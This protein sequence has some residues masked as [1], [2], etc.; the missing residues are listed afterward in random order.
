MPGQITFDNSLTINVS[1]TYSAGLYAFPISDNS[2]T[3]QLNG[4]TDINASDDNTNA[5]SILGGSV[6]I[7]NE[8]NVST[9]NGASAIE[10]AAINPTFGSLLT[11]YSPSDPQEPNPQKIMLEGKIHLFN[12][13]NQM[14]LDLAEGSIINSQLDI[15]QGNVSWQFH[16]PNAKWITIPGSTIGSQ[17][18]LIINF[19][20]G[21]TWQVP[22]SLDNQLTNSAAVAPLIIE[23]GGEFM[24][25]GQGTVLGNVQTELQ[26]GEQ[27]KFVLVKKNFADNGG[28]NL[29]LSTLSTQTDRPGYTLTLEQQNE[30]NEGYLYAILTNPEEPAPPDPSHKTL[31]WTPLGPSYS[32][33]IAPSSATI[34]QNSA[35][36]QQL[37]VNMVDQMLASKLL[38]STLSTSFCKRADSPVWIGQCLDPTDEPFSL[39]ALPLYDRITGR[40]FD[41]PDG[42]LGFKANIHGLGLQLVKE[43]SWGSIGTGLFNGKGDI[44]STELVTPVD[45]DADYLGGLIS[46][47]LRF[48]PFVINLGATYLHTKHK[49]HQYNNGQH[50]K[51]NTTLDVAGVQAGMA[52]PHY[53]GDWLVTPAAHIELW[54]THQPDSEIMVDG[55]DLYT[56]SKTKQ[57][58]RQLPLSVAIQGPDLISRDN[59]RV[60]LLPQLD[61]RFIPTWGDRELQTEVSLNNNKGSGVSISSPKMDRTSTELGIGLQMTGEFLDSSIRYSARHSSHILAQQISAD[62]VWRF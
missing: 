26:A 60:Q 11:T 58:Y 20:S 50:L 25:R 35:F 45:S 27:Q 8:L 24:V 13:F 54:H 19:A 46:G 57:N 39:W 3:V 62:F 31:P 17:G 42:H 51:S 12:G 44:N 23:Q 15:A 22:L 16:S 32:S 43:T 29:D 38:H 18:N 1:G 41:V 5:L 9:H 61:I 59:A 48:S 10:M 56:R 55:N 52:W 4:T 7:N 37:P 30:S 2:A 28:L 14:I 49:L 47:A 33:S 36:S 40:D 21:G 53:Y 34:A 6:Y